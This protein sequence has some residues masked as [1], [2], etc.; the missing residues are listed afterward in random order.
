MIIAEQCSWDSVGQ[1]L[2]PRRR[3]AN[4]GGKFAIDNCAFSGF[5]AKAFMTLLERERANRERC[6][7]VA[8]P[9][10]VGSARRTIEA[11]YAWYPVL[12]GWPIALVA[13]DGQED[14][15]IPWDMIAAVFIGGTDNF[16]Q[17]DAAMQ[18]ARC[19][20]VIGKWVHVGRVNTAARFRRWRDEAD[21]FDGTGVLMG[22]NARNEFASDAAQMEL[23]SAPEG[24]T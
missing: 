12:D 24:A 21:S 2:T 13:Q 16:K 11:F 23:I 1:L 7:F 22:K 17:S 4:G 3:H 20:K 18:I 5:E 6:I 15:P 14:L 9:D 8:S 19:A 10:I